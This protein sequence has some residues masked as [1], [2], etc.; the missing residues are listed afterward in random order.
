MAQKT[1]RVQP[2]E[3]RC[4]TKKGISLVLVE[5]NPRVAEPGDSGAGRPRM[6]IPDIYAF[7]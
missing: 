3:F 2:G 5:V 1:E 6:Q 7:R 4:A